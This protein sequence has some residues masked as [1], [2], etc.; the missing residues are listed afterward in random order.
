MSE[1]TQKNYEK[2][3]SLFKGYN[4]ATDR[5]VPVEKEVKTGQDIVLPLED[6]EKIVNNEELIGVAVCYCRH[7]ND[8]IDE[9]C[10]TTDLREK[11]IIIVKYEEFFII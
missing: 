11:C 4:I 2:N 5:V 1:G 9:Y 6:I 10:K 3:I 7:R 8:L